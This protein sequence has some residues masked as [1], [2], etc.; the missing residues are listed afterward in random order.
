MRCPL[1]LVSDQEAASARIAFYVAANYIEAHQYAQSMI[2]SFLGKGIFPSERVDDG[3]SPFY[4]LLILFWGNN[5]FGA[6]IRWCLIDHL[7]RESRRSYCK[8]GIRNIGE[9]KVEMLCI[10]SEVS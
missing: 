4:D 9:N 8:E 7:W 3:M 5:I 10:A 1:N 6:V 2:H